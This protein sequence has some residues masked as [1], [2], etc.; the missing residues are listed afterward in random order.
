M[1]VP[2]LSRNSLPKLDFSSVFLERHSDTLINA[3]AKGLSQIAQLSDQVA[4]SLRAFLRPQGL[5]WFLIPPGV[6]VADGEIREVMI[7]HGVALFPNFDQNQ[8]NEELSHLA[9][10]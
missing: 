2:L 9:A 6:V 1:P 5:P 4:K 8:N 10:H 7:L 3:L